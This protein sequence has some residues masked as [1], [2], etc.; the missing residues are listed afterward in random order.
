MWEERVNWI[1]NYFR[2]V[3][4]GPL[5]PKLVIIEFPGLWVD[6]AKSQASAG[7]GASFKLAYLCGALARDTAER[8]RAEVMLVSPGDWKGQLKKAVVDER[9]RR[10]LKRDVDYPDHVSDA[11]GIGLAM[12]GV[13]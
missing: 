11:V 13:L 8:S 9:I 10:A 12:Q 4:L 3:I 7:S 6:A 1:A 5:S 2:T